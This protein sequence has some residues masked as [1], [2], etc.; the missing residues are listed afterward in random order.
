MKILKIDH[1]HENQR[2][3]KYLNK[4]LPNAPKPVFRGYHYIF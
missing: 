1:L 4:L 2:I 3:D